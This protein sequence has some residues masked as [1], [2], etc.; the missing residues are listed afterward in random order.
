MEVCQTGG[1]V[2]V[3]GMAGHRRDAAIDRLANLPNHDKIVD[4]PAAQGPEPAFPRLGKRTR[5]GSKIA[6]NLEPMKRVTAGVIR[7]DLVGHVF[8]AGFTSNG[9]KRGRNTMFFGD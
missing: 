3:F 9:K 2:D 4:G 5:P 6:W 1:A 8:T 7:L